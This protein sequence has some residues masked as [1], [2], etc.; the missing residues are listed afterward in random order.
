MD[1]VN[2][3][4]VIRII[5]VLVPT[6]VHQIWLQGGELP[7]PLR[8]YAKGVSDLC[9]RVGWQ[10]SLW[11]VQDY[12]KLSSES[13]EVFRTLSAK[14][15]HISQQSNI[16]RYLIL[17]D[18][19]GLYLD[20]DVRLRKLPEALDGAWAHKS[21]ASA[22]PAGHPWALRIVSMFN[23]IDLSKHATGGSRLVR[24]SMGPDVNVWP[25]GA[26]GRFEDTRAALGTHGLLGLSIGSY[27][28]PPVIVV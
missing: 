8:G 14:C 7:E 19:G 11:S 6:H 4:F 12:K 22:C 10:Y 28:L 3:T 18:F 9:D 21:F 5:I 23:N 16:L 24:M 17:R 27:K 13:Q 15:C 1:Y 20:V 25:S 26:W 2:G